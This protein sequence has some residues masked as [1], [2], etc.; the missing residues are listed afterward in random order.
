MSGD[1]RPIVKDVMSPLFTAKQNSQQF[2]LMNWVS[3]FCG[4][5]LP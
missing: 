3:C 1:V 2:L 5:H 4:Y